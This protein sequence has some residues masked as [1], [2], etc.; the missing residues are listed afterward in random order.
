MLWGHKAAPLHVHSPFTFTLAVLSVGF[1]RKV[2]EYC[3]GLSSV[4]TLQADAAVS[5]PST[6]DPVGPEQASEVMIRRS[7]RR[8]HTD[9]IPSRREVILEM[10]DGSDPTPNLAPKPMGFCTVTLEAHKQS[11]VFPE[12]A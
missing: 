1:E 2:Q 3:P 6:G 11:S 7:Y 4:S 9:H 5:R 10:V 12:L 8:A